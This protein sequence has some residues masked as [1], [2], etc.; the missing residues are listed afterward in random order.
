LKTSINIDKIRKRSLI[1]N[2]MSIGGLFTLL[3]SVVLPLFAPTMSNLSLI[4]MISGLGVSMLGIYFANRW[5][6]KPRPEDQL[7]KALKT[8]SNGYH[9]FHYPAL[10]CDHI[11]LT[12]AGVILL[13]TVGLGGV[14]TYRKGKWKESMTMGRAVRWI[15]E[16]HLGDPIRAAQGAARHISERLNKLGIPDGKI[17]IKTVVVFT[18]PAVELEVEATPIPV[19]KVEKLRKQIPTNAAKMDEALFLQLD[20]FFN[21]L[22]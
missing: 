17:P 3:A 1:S 9:L 22:I 19:V 21:Q 7:D 13:E 12:P 8:L 11:L 18:H 6:R 10:P 2:I 15:V 5:V 16:E 14:F 4:L 20:E